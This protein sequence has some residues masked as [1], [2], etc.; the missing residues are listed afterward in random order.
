MKLSRLFIIAVLFAM[1]L[2][3]PLY[4]PT[5]LVNAA[6]QMLIAA[7]FASAFNVLAGQGGML[8]FGHSAYFAIGTFATIHGMNALDETGLLP[9]PFMPLLGALA[10]CGLGIVAGWFSTQR[11]GVYFSMI[12]LALAELLH[13]LAPHLKDIFGGEGGVSA[14]RMPAW[15]FNFGTSIEVYYLTLAWVAL[16]IALLYCFTRTPLGRLCLGLRENSHRLKFMG[17][18]VHKLRTMVF[19]ISATFSGLAGALLAMNNEA[20]NYVLFDM[21]LSTQVVLNS[22]IGGIGAFFGPALGAAVMTFFGYAVSDMTRTW[23]LYQGVIFVL[24]MMFMPAGLFSIG[25]WWSGNRRRF[26]AARL[27]G[28]LSGWVIGCIVAAAGF[29]FLCEFLALILALD[30]QSQLA[31][32]AAWPAVA[33]FDRQWLPGAFTTWLLPLALMVAGVVII[34]Y[35]NRKWQSLCEGNA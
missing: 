18:N 32:G 15:G 3:L 7:L 16:G 20:A 25:K 27:T 21:T 33:L 26:S 8:S 14:M 24:V 17:Y 30:Y 6:I 31:E 34:L 2:A 29:V 23:L 19:T 35:V 11:S 12:T 13:T 22:Y 1:L 5:S 4:L 28:V 9:T 10:G